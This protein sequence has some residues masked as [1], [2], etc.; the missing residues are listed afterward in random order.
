MAGKNAQRFRHFLTTTIIGGFAVILPIVIFIWVVR[1]LISLVHAVIAPLT[2]LINLEI[3]E[4]F[5][6]LIALVGLV[7]ICFLLGLF[8]RTRFGHGIYYYIEKHWFEKLPVYASIRDIVQQFTGQKKTPFTQVVLIDVLGSRMTGFVT[9]EDENSDDVSVFVPTAP[10]PTNGF[11]FHTK[12]HQLIYL[13]VKTEDALR[14]VVGMGA[15]S[16]ELIKDGELTDT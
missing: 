5:I 15:G 6:D 16:Q 13:N 2:G 10:N 9:D 12:K 7:A 14:T 4:V 11:V 8:I 3:P 1:L